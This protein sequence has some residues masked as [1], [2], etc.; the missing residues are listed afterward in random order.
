MS[1][2]SKHFTRTHANAGAKLVLR[3]PKG[4]DTGDWL[5]VLGADSDAFQKAK[6]RNIR[7]LQSIMAQGDKQTKDTEAFQKIQDDNI[8]DL[9]VSLVSGWSFEEDCTPENVKKLFQE[10]PYIA[11][12]V[13]TFAMDRANF[14]KLSGP[15]SSP[16]P[17]TSSN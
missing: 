11:D 16:T 4:V 13:D 8:L 12:L 2:F 17:E 7:N 15:S 9:Q 14:L 1:S 10:A 5:I 6:R 3:D